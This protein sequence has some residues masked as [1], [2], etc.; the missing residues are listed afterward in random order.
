MFVENAE[1]PK[2]PARMHMLFMV[3]NVCSCKIWRFVI[4]FQTFHLLS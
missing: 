3:F 2:Q 1:D 4:Y